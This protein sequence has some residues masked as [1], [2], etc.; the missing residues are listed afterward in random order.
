MMA[1]A[2]ASVTQGRKTPGKHR[3]EISTAFNQT[4]EARLDEFASLLRRRR[5]NVQSGDSEDLTGRV[6]ALAVE[7]NDAP[8]RRFFTQRHGSRRRHRR[9]FR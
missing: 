2:S 1:P 8:I 9:C 3:R 7:N 4:F 6:G 5:Q